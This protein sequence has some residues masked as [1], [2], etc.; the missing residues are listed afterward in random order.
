MSTC[1]TNALTACEDVQGR[2]AQMFMNNDS[3][4]FNEPMPWAEFLTSPINNSILTQTIS[5]GQGKV[6]TV[7]AVFERRL[8]ESEVLSDQANPNCVATDVPEDCSETYT[9]DTTV[10]RQANFKIDSTLLEENC[11]NNSDYLDRQIA[12]LIDAVDRTMATLLTNQSVALTGTWASD[13]DVTLDQLVVR[14]TKNATN[15]DLSAFTHSVIDEAMMK[16]GFGQNSVIA[17]GTALWSY[18][19]NT[20]FTGCCATQGINLQAQFTEFG[21][22]MMYDRRLD[23]ALGGTGLES[24]VC[25][26]NV[27]AVLHYTKSPWRDGIA[28]LFKEG[29][30]YFS[31][32]V[33][34]PRLGLPYDLHVKDDCGTI[35]ITVTGTAKV[36]SLPLDLFKTGDV[37]DGVNWFTQILVD[38]S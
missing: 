29:S 17:G 13:V 33:V 21:R 16:T 25:Q 12:K 26:P 5:P 6:K 36:V 32:V 38:N 20:A 3:T 1:L 24:V 9:I 35:N 23:T 10:N 11:E 2:I 37:Y 28:P 22:A 15:E 27:L 14:T 8:L 18:F 7:N 31:G 30:D 4:F 34:S 19:R